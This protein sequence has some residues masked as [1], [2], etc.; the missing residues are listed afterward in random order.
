[1]KLSKKQRESYVRRFQN[2][3]TNNA[4]WHNEWE[5]AYE[6]AAPQLN[7]VESD[8]YVTEGENL[9]G[10]LYDLTLVVA[11]NKLVS[12]L[13]NGLTPL[14]QTWDNLKP[15]NA[16]KRSKSPEQIEKIADELYDITDTMFE[17]I[18]S[19]NF[20]EAM[21]DA[22][23]NFTIG[24]LILKVNSNSKNLNRPFMFESFNPMNVYLEKADNIGN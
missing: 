2:A 20:Y 24:T 23:F 5:R 1:M 14:F 6:L 11:T 22:Y 17:Y 9:T 13:F 19:S 8:G 10:G 7:I 15:S 21:A 3:Y 12:K 18:N 16:L 4:M